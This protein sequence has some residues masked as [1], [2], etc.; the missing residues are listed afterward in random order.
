MHR[1]ANDDPAL[2]SATHRKRDKR[3]GLHDDEGSVAGGK[4]SCV[5]IHFVLY[6]TYPCGVSGQK[7][8]CPQQEGLELVVR[9]HIRYLVSGPIWAKWFV[10]KGGEVGAY[11]MNQDRTPG[12]ARNRR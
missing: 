12:R 1:R 7:V 10:C 11:Y 8:S 3:A 6:S 2:L 9:E 4:R 5:A